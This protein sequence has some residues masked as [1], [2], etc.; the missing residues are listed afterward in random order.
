MSAAPRISLAI[1]GAALALGVCASTLA[2]DTPPPR[3]PPSWDTLA[4]CGEMTAD[5]ARLACFDAAMKAAGFKRNTEAAAAEHRKRFG[6]PLPQVGAPKRHDKEEGAKV[7]AET[8]PAGQAGPATTPPSPRRAAKA[9]A[10]APAAE[11]EDRITV[12]I[13][14]VATTQ[15]E[16]QLLLFTSDG[17]IWVQT[18]RETVRTPSKGQSVTIRHTKFGGYFCDLPKSRSIR[19]QRER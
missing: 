17:A 13:S 14:R 16:G 12:E 8:A 2:E 5:V 15:P 1:A 6:L 11:D 19:C 3:T 4:R 9:S 7:A 10:A 18:D